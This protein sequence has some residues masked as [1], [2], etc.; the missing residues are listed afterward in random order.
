MNIIFGLLRFAW[1]LLVYGLAVIGALYIFLAPAPP[2][3][4]VIS[5]ETGPI[6]YIVR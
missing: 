2:S 3:C 6:T 1:N 5:P 4:P